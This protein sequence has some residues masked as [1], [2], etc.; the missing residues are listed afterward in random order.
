[1]RFQYNIVS[2]ILFTVFIFSSCKDHNEYRIESEFS[3][4]LQRF[5]NEAA[6]RGR[7]FNVQTEGLIIEFADLKNNTAGLT[8]YE[9]P[10][11]IEVDRTYWND[12]SSTAGADL[13][14]ENLIFHELG[15]GLLGR[16]HLN[17][18][19]ENGDWK[20]IM[21]G[22][23]MENEREWNINYRGER[24]AYY[25]DELFNESSVY[26][27][28]ASTQ[29]LAELDTVGFS[30]SFSLFANKLKQS[31][32]PI[33]EEVQY[34]RTLDLTN[35]RLT[36]Q[37]KA[38][39]VYLLLYLKDVVN[40]LKTDFSFQLTIQSSTISA[41]DQFGI[42]FKKDTTDTYSE[43]DDYF[44]I[45]NNQKMYMGNRSWY[46]YFTELSKPI[47][48]GNGKNTLKLFKIGGMLYYFIN[49][50]YCYSIEMVGDF[51]KYKFGFMLPPNG[52][53]HLY[54]I[55]LAQKIK[56]SISTRMIKAQSAEFEVTSVKAFN[57]KAEQNK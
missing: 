39:N 49:G 30:P 14:K 54:D 48:L 12:I 21:C 56:S 10:I 41:K 38:T 55:I 25:I 33:V 6:K 52:T 29:F 22:G 42:I 15:H 16:G 17:S 35:E 46:S 13:M 26:P 47:I 9:D 7:T 40:D 50:Q 31:D 4:Y 57:L 20:S 32:F 23:E 43:F 24:R 18:T 5:E 36:Y 53:M 2:I 27:D 19:L 45:N 3:E 37:S 1:M 44:T 8:H 28:F 51:K 11:R 34:K